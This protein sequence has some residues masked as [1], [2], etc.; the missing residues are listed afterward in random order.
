M[1]GIV[2]MSFRCAVHSRKHKMGSVKKIFTEML[3]SA[4]ARGSAATGVAMMT[5]A[6]DAEKTRAWVLRSPL[7]AKEFVETEDYK[8]IMEMVDTDCLSIIGHTRAV[9]G[10]AVAEDNKN[11]H[12]HVH[13]GIIGI[14]NGCITNDDQ[15]WDK[16]S[17]HI[18]P[19]GKCDSEVIVALVNHFVESGIAE[20]TEEA[21]EMALSESEAW[22]ALAFLDTG[23]PNK[24]YLVKDKAT[25][26]SLGWWNA[27]EIGVFASN[28]DYIEKAYEKHGVI[29]NKDAIV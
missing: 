18:T 17:E 7:P 27:P 15:L 25:P 9:T 16:F 19:K 24:M 22:F 2:G 1:C 11:N 12:P 4:Q 5:C 10:N 6:P 29:K 23:S 28:W 26:L 8:K 20:N 21:I 3:V 13:G 14:H